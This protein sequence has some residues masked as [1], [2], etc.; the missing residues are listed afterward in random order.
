[1]CDDV[2]ALAWFLVSAL[3]PLTLGLTAL[4]TVLLG[5][6][7]KAQA[8]AQRVAKVLPSDVSDQVVQLILRTRRDSPIL[9]AISIVLMVWTSS[10]AVGVVERVISRLLG[11]PR[12]GMVIL[13]LRQL[14]L[15]AGVVLVVVL[16]VLA[17]A[18]ATNLQSRLGFGGPV[19]HW[20]FTLGSA[21]AIGAVCTS[22]YHFSPRD[23]IPWRDAAVGAIPAAIALELTPTVAA[24]YLRWIAGTTPV[25]V[26]LVLA[27][28]LFTCYIAAIALMV[29][30]AVAVR[31]GERGG[32]VAT[33]GAAKAAIAVQSES[34][35][36][37][38][39]QD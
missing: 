39:Q 38:A 37:I 23:G 35:P 25:Q 7:A 8:L 13:K 21:L 6:Y 4:G 20:L 15:A 26:F 18:K 2:P 24:Y 34:A 33:P 3:V 28:V 27:G 12:F 32:A 17:G 14:G 36:G 31:H 9:I 16:M 5:D 22:L 19:A 29:G 1:V 30:A 10:G 11:R